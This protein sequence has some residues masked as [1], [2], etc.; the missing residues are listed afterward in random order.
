MEYKTPEIDID[1][2]VV[3]GD[4][5]LLG[6]LSD[7]WL[8]KGQKAYGVPGRKI[9]FNETIGEAV[10]RNIREEFD[11]GVTRY[12]IFC[13]NANYYNGHFIGIGVEVE[14]D[15]EPKLLKTEGW[16]KWEW[17][18]KDNTPTNLFPSAKNLVESYIQHKFCI[19]E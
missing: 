8:Y 18:E 3:K 7:K 12:K 4:K 17:F 10:K 2:L 6:L 11:C 14:I 1:I 15:G 19:S 9:H 13:V 16:E 5:L